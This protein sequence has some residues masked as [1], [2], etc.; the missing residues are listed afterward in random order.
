MLSAGIL[1]TMPRQVAETPPSHSCLLALALVAVHQGCLGT[2]AWG[3]E[4][5]CE[6]EGLRRGVWAGP[7]THSGL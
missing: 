1:S 4:G 2:L 5:L 3:C 6:R 7:D